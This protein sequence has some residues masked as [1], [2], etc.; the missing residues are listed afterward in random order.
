VGF[1]AEAPAAL[2]EV[3]LFSPLMPCGMVSL[4]HGVRLLSV[5]MEPGMGVSVS[6]LQLTKP[7]SFR[8]LPC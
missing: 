5:P 1:W 7:L 8:F 6:D 4:C 3:A 2:Q